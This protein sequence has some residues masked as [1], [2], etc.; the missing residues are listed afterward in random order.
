MSNISA[1]RNI[2]Y[3]LS[4]EKHWY[5]L[6]GAHIRLDNHV[7][8]TKQFFEF[9]E[10]RFVTNRFGFQFFIF[11]ILLKSTACSWLGFLAVFLGFLS[12]DNFTFS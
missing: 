3:C 8:I 5:G 11:Y 6:C 1:I 7:Q 12:T 10:S 9:I 4:V 2:T